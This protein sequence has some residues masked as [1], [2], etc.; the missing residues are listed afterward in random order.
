MAYSTWK[1]C[2]SG[3]NTVIARSYLTVASQA[4]GA[5]ADTTDEPRD[6]TER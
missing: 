3:E 4:H 6:Q 5:E 1:R 2:P